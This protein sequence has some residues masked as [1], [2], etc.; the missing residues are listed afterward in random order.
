MR[1]LIIA[2]FL[3]GAASTPAPLLAQNAARPPMLASVDSSLFEGLTFRLVGPSRGGRSTTVAGV[4]SQPRTFYMGVASG[5]VF[6][7]TDGGES[8]VPVTDHQ[9][10]LG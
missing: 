10:P 5:G 9:V 2:S 7:T 3:V 8:W 1:H 6:K 4:P